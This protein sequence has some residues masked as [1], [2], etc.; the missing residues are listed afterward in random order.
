MLE[1]FSEMTL[2]SAASFA[3]TAGRSWA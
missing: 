3:A 1:D 2:K